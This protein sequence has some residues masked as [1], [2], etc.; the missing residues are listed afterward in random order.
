MLR[1]PK[2]SKIE[3]VVPKEEE[4]FLCKGRIWFEVLSLWDLPTSIIPIEINIH[5][6]I[7]S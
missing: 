2:H 1:R 6:G 5:A 3:V 4:G 7:T